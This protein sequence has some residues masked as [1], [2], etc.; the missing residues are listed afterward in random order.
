[1]NTETTKPVI[2]TGDRPTGPLH[3]G[4]LVGSLQNRV[5]MQDTHKQYVLI[6]DMQALTDNAHDPEKVRR[7]I[8]EVMLDYLAVGLDPEK[9]TFCLQSGL[10]ALPELTAIYMNLVSVGRLERNPTIRSEI[11]S[12]GFERN[13]PVGFL[14]YPVSQAADITAFDATVVPVGED[15]LPIIEQTNEIVR[16]I[17]NQAGKPVLKECRAVVPKVGRLPAVDGS[18][19]MSKSSGTAIHLSASSD[20]IRQAV[21]MMYTDPGHLK[22][23]DPGKVEGNVVFTYLD[24]FDPDGQAVSELKSH[25]R[26][27]GLGDMKVKKRLEELLESVIAPI[28]KRRESFAQDPAEVLRVLKIGTHSGNSLSKRTLTAA[29][30]AMGVFSFST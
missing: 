4:H 25:Y 28:R 29:K 22:V 9:T 11:K 19:K 2:L 26:R 21:R 1:M 27:G 3:L 24:A 12:R 18:S 15:Q 14:N 30:D 5:A 10:P 13:V 20:E 8:L 6:A 16:K 23:S 7:S 17:N